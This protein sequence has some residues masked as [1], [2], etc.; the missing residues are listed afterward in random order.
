[1]SSQGHGL[2]GI[3]SKFYNFYFI[4][5]SFTSGEHVYVIDVFGLFKLKQI[6]WCLECEQSCGTGQQDLGFGGHQ[7]LGFERRSYGNYS[8]CCRDVAL[9]FK[10]LVVVVG[11]PF[12]FSNYY[13]EPWGI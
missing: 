9:F 5:T 6:F 11:I 2:C 10:L 3:A 8:C 12:S 7:S 4:R 1:M 13:C